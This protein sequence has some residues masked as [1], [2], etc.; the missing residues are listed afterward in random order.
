MSATIRRQL[1]PLEPLVRRIEA[2]RE[3][4]GPAKAIGKAARGKLSDGAIKDALSGT[5]LG[6]A[7]HP[8]LTDVVIGSFLST[9]VLDLLGGDESGTAG[10]RLLTVGV[11]AYPPAALTGLSDWADTEISDDAVRR[12]GIVHVGSNATALTLYTASL[13]S[14]RR[15]RRSQAR[16]FSLLGGS[17]LMLGGYLGGHMTLIQGV[18]ADQTVFDR[19]PSDWTSAGAAA[20]VPDGIPKRVVVDDTPVLLLRDGDELF[21]IHDRC[22]HRG[23]SLSE[24]SIEGEEIVCGCHAPD[25]LGPSWSGDGATTGIRG[26]RAGRDDRDP[27]ARPH[28]I[29]ARG[30]AGRAAGQAARGLRSGPRELRVRGA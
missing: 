1:T 2:A 12:V 18:G 26:T 14:R 23:C 19:G 30:P 17:A 15:G 6:H 28:L 3:L 24:G 5:W 21:A 13:V 27:P 29:D 16:L 8:L 22:S 7:L 10:R 9:T 4:D 11:L 20:G 25:R